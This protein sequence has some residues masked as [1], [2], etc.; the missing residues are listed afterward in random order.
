MT[1]F[2]RPPSPSF[3]RVSRLA[4]VCGALTAL[5]TAPASAETIKAHYAL[6]LLGLS[7]GSAYASGVI[8]PQNYRLDIAMK[9]SGLANLVNN[10][11]G[12]AT[13]TGKLNPEGP[14]PASFANTLANSYETR[15]IRMSLGGNAVRL[16]EVKPEPWDAAQR[17][18][19][20]A[21]HKQHIID[22]VSALIMSVPAG[23][24][25]VGP[26]ACNRTIRVFDGVTRFDVQLR[27]VETREA[28]A[29]GFAGPVSVCTA[30]YT[31][32]A[33]HRPDSSV[34]KYMAENQEMSVWLAPLPEAP[35]QFKPERLE[36]GPSVERN[37]ACFLAAHAVRFILQ[38]AHLQRLRRFLRG[39]A[40]AEGRLWME[41]AV[42]RFE[43]I[44]ELRFALN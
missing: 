4:A 21:E 33:G 19:V 15:T 22:P 18:P 12:A 31:P 5:S 42:R 36:R 34:T 20:N 24:E 44:G 35:V 16:L 29:K 40:Q 6:S 17:L 9:T 39:S 41:A 27:Y 37:L 10:T 32:I 14:S 26:T 28:K 3:R 13:A 25:L 8:E 2:K 30:H 1:D 7:I 43:T 38:I 11:R 23:Q